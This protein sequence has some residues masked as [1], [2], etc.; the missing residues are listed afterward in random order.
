MSTS[1][2]GLLSKGVDHLIA[3]GSLQS[4]LEGHEPQQL[5]EDQRA[6]LCRLLE[7]AAELLAA[8]SLPVTA[9]RAKASNRA[10][11][12]S[13]VVQQRESIR[14]RTG[15]RALIG[16]SR[17]RQSLAGLA[18]SL[19]DV[20]RVDG[21][22]DEITLLF[23]ETSGRFLVEVAEGDAAAFEGLMDG[24]PCACVGQTGG[25]ALRVTG[26][27]GQALFEMDLDALKAAWKGADV[28]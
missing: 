28:D 6:E 25:D 16:S 2:A 24:L 18:L 15:W 21:I 11:F 4:F 13:A 10:R 3:G 12:L 20:P 7:Q 17:L 23:S 14:S 22:G 5:A 8:G 26:L 9:P 27:D 19:A 1:L